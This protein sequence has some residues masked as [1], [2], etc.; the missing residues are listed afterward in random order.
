MCYFDL[1]NPIIVTVLKKYSAA[2]P[3]M[4]LDYAGLKK[5]TSA[6]KAN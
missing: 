6:L 5:K 1:V 3:K 4:V 2:K